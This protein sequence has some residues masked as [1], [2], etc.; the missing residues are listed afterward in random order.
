MSDFRADEVQ[1]AA[2][3]PILSQLSH[4][5]I[6]FVRHAQS[7]VN[8]TGKY[9]S[10]D[11]LDSPLSAEG[12]KQARVL[13]ESF[14]DVHVDFVLV[15]TLA[16][17]LETATIGLSDKSGA[18]WL[19]CDFARETSMEIG[20][21][22][23]EPWQYAH[24]AGYKPCNSRR[25]LGKSTEA[26][27]GDLEWTARQFPHIDFMKKACIPRAEDEASY[28]EVELCTDADTLLPNEF[29]RS[30]DDRVDLLRHV[31]AA[32]LNEQQ[33]SAE[34]QGS[35]EE[36]PSGGDIVV[37][38]HQIFLIRVLSHMGC[39]RRFDN[40]QA[41]AFPLDAFLKSSRASCSGLL[42]TDWAG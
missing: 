22:P 38:S 23:N 39:P 34:A 16:R 41:H 9:F 8:L 33:Q 11:H 32:L 7:E 14:A 36:E 21:N 5:T 6:H 19:A 29:V 13:A 3:C 31:V 27:D 25:A 12:K 26:T 30:L 35:D 37:V 2:D 1:R 18:Q 10:D 24:I 4:R 17:A 40:C 20:R 42:A 28:Q 15:S